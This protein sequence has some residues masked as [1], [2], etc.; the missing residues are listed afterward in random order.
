MTPAE[1]KDT[2]ARILAVVEYCRK[3]EARITAL[4]ARQ[5]PQTYNPMAGPIPWTSS[6]TEGVTDAEVVG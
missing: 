2:T 4:E 1:E 3:L 5:A 6:W